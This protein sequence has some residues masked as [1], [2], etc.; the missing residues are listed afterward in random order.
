VTKTIFISTGEVSGDLQGALLVTAL[1]ARAKQQ[2]IDI[3]IV[4]LGGS[5]MA[6]AGATILGD[7]T[8]IGSVGIIEALAYVLP[9]IRVQN[10][11]KKYLKD[12]PPD[13]IVPID[14]MTPNIGIGN[15]AKA[16]FPNVPVIYYI[17]P[18][19]WVWSVN[20]K[21]TNFIINFTDTIL[22]IFPEE[23]K[24]FANKGANAKFVGHPLVDRAAQMPTRAA[25]R[26]E[27]GIA[28]DEIAIALI[29]ASRKQELVLL[30]PSIFTAAKTIQDRL[31]HVKFWIPLSRIEYKEAIEAA[32]AEYQLNATLVT[33]NPDR[34]ICAADV[35]ITKS[36]T[37]SLELALLNIPQ[38]VIYRVGKVT[39]WIAKN[40][41]RLTLP[42]ISPTNL[43]E[44]KP[45]VTELV[46]DRA[47]PDAIV[48]ET[49]ELLL[50]P[51]RRQKML[52]DYH[53]M[54][55]ALGDANV[56][57]RVADEIL[58]RL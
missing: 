45:I 9:T 17:A 7:T 54:R 38:V 18:Q 26:A 30:M 35:A 28:T 15:Y 32:I 43:V 27:L 33:E 58:A 56:C 22:S 13:A 6:A 52:D 12:H 1:F 16:N 41:L 49:L 21:N 5:K 19:E 47:T 2:G 50:N 31:P 42:Y 11:A 3:K 40:V 4:A 10:I 48:S 20:S 57:D 51:E 34:A 29:P 39:G 36:G 37:V 55:V 8:A 23:Q 53:Q 46:Q 14:Y 44:M 24:Y 25:S